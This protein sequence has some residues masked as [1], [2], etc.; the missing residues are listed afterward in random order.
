MIQV[1]KAGMKQFLIVILI[2]SIIVTV[3]SYIRFLIPLYGVIADILSLVCIIIFGYEVLVHYTAVFTYTCDDKRLKI[4]RTIGK[5]NKEVEFLRA[6]VV[7][8]SS[9]K[10]DVE[11]IH[12]FNPNILSGKKTK[13]ITY[14]SK[15]ITEAVLIEVDDEMD[16]YLKALKK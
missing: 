1:K 8:V 15:R 14:N 10:P 2:T 9:K 5:R 16:K 12:N 4:N 3:F 7:S 6:S 13:Y 11:F